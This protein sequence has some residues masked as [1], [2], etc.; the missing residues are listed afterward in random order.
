MRE[1]S[2]SIVHSMHWYMV[3]FPVH[4]QTLIPKTDVSVYNNLKT[5]LSI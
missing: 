3:Y 1:E 2:I 5:D 4:I